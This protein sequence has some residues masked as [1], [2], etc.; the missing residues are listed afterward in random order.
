[1]SARTVFYSVGI[2]LVY[3]LYMPFVAHAGMLLE[4]SDTLTDSGPSKMSN[5]TIEFIIPSGIPAGGKLVITPDEGFVIPALFDHT[6]VDFAVATTSPEGFIDRPISGVASTT[7]D[8][9]TVNTGTS[10]SIIIEINTT[11]G[12]SAGD[13]VQIQLGTV[14]RYQGF[15]DQLIS[16]PP[17]TGSYR[18]DGATKNVA[19]AT[20][21]S[22]NTLVAIIEPVSVG[23]IN[24]IDDT[25]PE[26]V[27]VLPPSGILLQTGTMNIQ[28]YAETSEPTTCRYSDTQG[29]T[30]PLMT[31]F[32]DQTILSS[33]HTVILSGLVD[34]TTYTIYIVCADNQSN[35]SDEYE[36]EF[37]IGIAPL[38][39]GTGGVLTGPPGESGDGVG[40][41]PF[42]FWW[43]IPW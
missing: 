17:D 3:M 41:G 28:V 43:A 16:N 7:A 39:P 6:D 5:H 22:W 4:F 10:S 21:D 36:L 27:T 35:Y 25:P 11:T 15:G 20:I 26:L 19:N 9:V 24:T 42:D 18:I 31:D 34:D 2:T 1:M 12:I 32:F 23:P 40:G 30:F 37:S 29:T 33:T 14:A 13:R 8:R 38:E